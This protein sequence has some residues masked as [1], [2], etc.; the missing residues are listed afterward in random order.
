MRATSLSL[1]VS[2][3]CC[4]EAPAAAGKERPHVLFLAVDDLNHWVGHLGRNE[5]AKTP[6]ID[7]LARRGVTFT[8]AYCAAPVCNPSRA[9]LMSGLRPGQTGVY[10]NGQDWQK[11]IAAEKT[12]T[13]QFRKA[14]YRAFGAGKIYH[15]GAHR[16]AEWDD[17]LR[18]AGKKLTASKR[19]PDAKDN[20]VGGI[21]FAPLQGEDSAL[22]DYHFVSYGVA[23]LK[24]KHDRPFFLAV[25]LQKPHM[26][27]NVPKRYYDLFPLDKIKLPPHKKDD[28]DD[29]PPAGVKMARPGGDHAAMVKSGRWKEAVQAYLAAV[30]Y[31][32]AQ[33]GRL[34]DALDRSDHKDNTVVVLWGDHGWHLGEKSHWRKFALWEEATRAPLIWVA[35]GVTKPK[36]R[37]GRPVDFMSVY[38]TLCELCAVAVPKHVTAPSLVPLLR[39]QKAKWDAPAI[40][41]YGRNNHAVRTERWRYIRYADGGEELYDHDKDPHEWTNLAGDKKLAEVKKGLAKL[42]PAENKPARPRD[43]GK[44]K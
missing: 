25:G 36:G 30:A 29:V 27:W 13:T 9:A 19:H 34:I 39:D 18:G 6:N 14:G 4:P 23:Q 38:P 12:L 44:G 11:A 43:K 8:R 17:Y 37:C 42:L 21:R 2:L 1:A 3:L 24:N 15:G 10:D 35:P 40:T 20:G 33:V 7:R 41:T 5:Q 32:D 31:C 26:P 16:A 28:L 22:P